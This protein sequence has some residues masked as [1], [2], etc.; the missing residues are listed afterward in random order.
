[1]SRS[2]GEGG[3]SRPAR[4]ARR[5][6]CGDCIS[7]VTESQYSRKTLQDTSG[8]LAEPAVFLGEEQDMYAMMMFPINHSLASPFTLFHAELEEAVDMGA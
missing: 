2:D 6:P 5:C 7:S 4:I 8:P 1:M 3:N